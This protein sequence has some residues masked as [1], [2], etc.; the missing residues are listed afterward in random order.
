[1]NYKELFGLDFS[2]TSRAIVLLGF[3]AILPNVLGLVR[4]SFEGYP[5][6]FFQILIFLSAF[7]YGPLGGALSG[8][9]G[10]V[11]TALVVNP[12]ILVGNVILGFFT[13]VFFRK[14][15]HPVLSVMSAFAVQLP[16]LWVSDI[17]WAH[18]PQAAVEKIVIA[19]LV[20]NLLWA[21]IA[22]KTKDSVKEKMVG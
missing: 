7:V 2:F 15:L 14:G 22:W 16:W 5:V 21:L 19:L 17:Y 3:L 8:A 1:M 6:H 12:Y 13:G 18:M 10:S 20:S 4:I 9:A 11:Y